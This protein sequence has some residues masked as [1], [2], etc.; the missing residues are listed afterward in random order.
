MNDISIQLDR[1]E[2][3]VTQILEIV[4]EER[5]PISDKWFTERQVMKIL[6]FS[7]RRMK[8]LRR[9]NVIRVSTATGRNFLHYKA[10]VENYIYDH[11]SV[12]NRRKRG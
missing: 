5:L 9:E 10:D 7:K 8:Q 3:T 6:N 4:S 12:R 11:S 2:K 1:I